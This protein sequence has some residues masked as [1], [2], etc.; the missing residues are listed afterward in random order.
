MTYENIRRATFLSRPNRFIANVQLE[1]RTEVVHV[2]NTGRCKELLI[3]NAEIFVQENDNPSR[4]TRFDLI[5]VFKG[6]RL[7][8]MDSQ[9]PN[10]IFEE[11]LRRGEFF[12]DITLLKRE[13]VYE[14]SRFDFYV[15]QGRRRTFIEVKGVTLEEDGVAMFPDAPTQRGVKH[16]HELCRSIEHGYEAYIVFIVQMKG[17]KYFTPN[18]KT[19][20][21]FGEALSHAKACGVNVLALDCCVTEDSV[22]AENFVEVRL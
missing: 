17:V 7:I 11:W 2:K 21:A 18:I 16:I 1:G 4:K 13:T 20:E 12:K 14:T 19:H 9:A 8:N 22:W 15:E 5:S 6:D 3:P 10:K